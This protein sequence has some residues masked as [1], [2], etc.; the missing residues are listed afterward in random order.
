MSIGDQQV[1]SPGVAAHG[2]TNAEQQKGKRGWFGLQ[3][4]AF[5]IGLGLLIFVVRRVGVQPLF[6]ALGRIGFGFFAVVALNGLR[7]VLRSVS[8]RLAVPPEHRN[9]GFRSTLAA[10][11]AGESVTFLTFTGPVLGE[12]TKAALLRRHMPLARG[13]PALV[14]DNLIYNLSVALFILSGALVMLANYELPAPVRFALFAVAAGVVFALA[15]V[16]F[17]A[18]R[19]VSPLRSLLDLFARVSPL[20]N[21]IGKKRA[22]IEE[23]ESHVMNFGRERPRAL[24]GMI[25]VDLLA[26]A[27]SVTEVF[28]ALHLLGFEARPSAAYVIES[29]TKVINLLFGFV[30][31]T[32]GVYEGGTGLILNV[33]GYATAT[34]VTLAI[35]RKAAII[36]WTLIGLSILTSRALPAAANKL[37][38][39]HPRIR[40]TMDSLVLSNIAHRPARTLVSVLGVAIGVL[41]IV[42]TTGL[43]H[44]VLR[45]RGKRAASVGA[46][47]M[48]RPSGS[49]GF[50][51]TETF[52]LQESLADELRRIEGVRSV[53]AVGQAT[54]PAPGFGVRLIDGIRFDEYAPMAN[55]QIIEG[56]GLGEAGDEAIVDSTW[57]RENK[58]GVGGVV[59]IFEREFRV[60]GVYEPPGGGRVKIPLR[61]MQE[62]IGG[63]NRAAA[64]LVS[65]TDPARQEDVAA[66][67]RERLP[68]EQILFTRDLPELYAASLP[69]LDVFISII[70]AV[71]AAISVL[72]ILLAMYTTVTE[73][74]RQ[75]GI[76]KS[77]GMP[78][79]T[80]AWVIEQ[81]AIIISLLGVVLG[82]VLV[83]VARF[84]V[85]RMT[86][87]V[88]EV[89][90]QWVAVAL[91]I[92]LLGG[93]IGALYPALRA[94]RADAVKALSY[95]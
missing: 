87:L 1:L 50:G 21:V 2:S 16:S 51:G 93:T 82:L 14:V 59:Q 75:I 77:L 81:E 65:V 67:I 53:T 69:A 94:A 84:G 33:L 3:A 44:G 42:F 36:F 13:V 20:R 80:I 86:S 30:P 38:A 10:R 88:I 41:L 45:E 54:Q 83:Y 34:G 60:V 26:H 78:N 29:L 90:W 23:L 58:T 9:F 92:G 18:W 55:M 73:R 5:V 43:A 15:S 24:A 62:Q 28:V 8:M 11:I 89:E 76:L 68:E 49:I 57:Q 17:A 70:V 31:G 61:T 85:M 63:E 27:T 91:A 40:K 7:H 25:T 72:V 95:E 66:R 39:R 79:R 46:E 48:V 71:A 12:A 56:R 52:A 4:I 74:T 64:M 35:V 47:I 19:R 32:I 22:T 37:A 6:D